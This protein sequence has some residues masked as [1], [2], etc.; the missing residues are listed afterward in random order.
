MV[1]FAVNNTRLDLPAFVGI[2]AEHC[3]LN[4]I[5]DELGLEKHPD[6]TDMGRTEK[7]FDFFGF[8]F[9]PEGL[10]MPEKTI[11]KFLALTVRL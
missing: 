3:L 2:Y 10:S 8:N 4:E 9:S 6:K 7:V 1:T 11:G 5:F